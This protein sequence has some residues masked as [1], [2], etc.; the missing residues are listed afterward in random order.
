M[1]CMSAP[2]YE[3]IAILAATVR[4]WTILYASSTLYLSSPASTHDDNAVRR[5]ISNCRTPGPM[6]A[7]A[8]NE[9]GVALKNAMQGRISAL[10]R[11]AAESEVRM[12]IDAEQS[13]LQPAIDNTV[14]GL[15]VEW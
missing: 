15:Q 1:Y 8:L 13:W 10:A 2:E 11:V 12:M 6:A 5:T 14:Y 7:A 9:D 4:N 3:T